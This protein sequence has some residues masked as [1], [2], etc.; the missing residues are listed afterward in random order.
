MKAVSTFLIIRK[1]KNI[2]NVPLDPSVGDL[3]SNFSILAHF[4]KDKRLFKFAFCL[5]V[6][7]QVFQ[8]IFARYFLNIF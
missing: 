1:F 2:K 5:F 6:Q 3:N 7:F 4:S 8:I